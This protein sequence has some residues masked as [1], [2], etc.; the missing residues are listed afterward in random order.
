LG[1]FA[2]VCALLPSEPGGSQVGFCERRD[3]LR[4]HGAGKPFQ[5]SVGGAAGRQRYLLLEDDLHK[6]WEPGFAVPQRRWPESLDDRRQM[7]VAP[8]QLGDAVGEGLCGQLEPHFYLTNAP[9]WL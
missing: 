4:R 8:R 9:R 1:E 5:P 3:T 2:D 6:R 7:R